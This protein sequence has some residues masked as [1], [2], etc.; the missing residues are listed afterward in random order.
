MPRNSFTKPVGSTSRKAVNREAFFYDFSLRRKYEERRSP[1]DVYFA[2]N[3]EFKTYLELK[4]ADIDFIYQPELPLISSN[5]RFNERSKSWDFKLVGERKIIECK[6]QW[7]NS[8]THRDKRYLFLLEC[9]LAESNGYSITIISD[10]GK[11]P[12]KK[13]FQLGPYTAVHYE[14]LI[15]GLHSS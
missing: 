11:G 7:I 5:E 9:H 1:N 12:H 2:S 15:N 14:D 10:L 8:N 3:L 13:P 6:G 4:R